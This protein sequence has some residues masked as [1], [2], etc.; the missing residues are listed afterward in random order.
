MLVV[1]H[2]IFEEIT[3][4]TTERYEL[5]RLILLGEKTVKEVHCEIRVPIS[6]LYRYLKRLQEGFSPLERLAD[7]P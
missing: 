4:E 5:I 6:T 2:P 3:L 1:I 7:K